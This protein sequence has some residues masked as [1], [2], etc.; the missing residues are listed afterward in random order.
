MPLAVLALYLMAFRHGELRP[1][2]IG[3]LVR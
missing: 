3:G 2:E 1:I